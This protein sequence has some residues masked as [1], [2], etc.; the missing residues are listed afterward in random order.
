MPAAIKRPSG[1]CTNPLRESLRDHSSVQSSFSPEA[2]WAARR[3]GRRQATPAPAWHTHSTSSALPLPPQGW[4]KAQLFPLL[5]QCWKLS[6]ESP[7]FS[8]AG[9]ATALSSTEMGASVPWDLNTEMNS[10]L[11]QDFVGWAS[12]TGRTTH[13]QPSSLFGTTQHPFLLHDSKQHGITSLM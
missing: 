11:K 5:A 8:P 7:P 1:A 12:K 3:W 6:Q 10:F 9:R 2:E 4:H 13:I